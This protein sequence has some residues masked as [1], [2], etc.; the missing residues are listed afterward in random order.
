MSGSSDHNSL[1]EDALN[2]LRAATELEES[3]NEDHRI[4]A[5]TKVSFDRCLVMLV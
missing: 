3:S 5:A 2:L 1:L 4:E